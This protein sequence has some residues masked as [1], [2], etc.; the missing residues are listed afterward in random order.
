MKKFAASVLSAVLLLAPLCAYEWGGLFDNT[1]KITFAENS[2]LL[3]QSD[4]LFMWFSASLN[5]EGNIYFKGEGM[6]KFNHLNNLDGWSKNL[7]IIDIDLLKFAG[8]FDTSAGKISASVGRFFVSDFSGA[9]FTQVSDGAY[10]NFTMPKTAISAYAGYTGL[11]NSKTVTILG[12]EYKDGQFYTTATPFVPVTLS[13]SFPSLFMNQTLSVQA[14][15]FFRADG[16]EDNRAYGTLHLSG[17]IASKVF[18]TVLTDFGTKNFNGLMNFSKVSVAYFPKSNIYINGG[19]EY[20]SGE[21]FGLK[22]FNGFSSR[23]AY[24]SL[25]DAQTTGCVVPQVSASISLMENSVVLGANIKS[26]FV[27]PDES[28]EAKGLQFDVNAI[29][30]VFSDLQTAVTL[31]AF[32]GY[33]NSSED[34]L[35]LTLKAAFSF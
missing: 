29:Y 30:N 26:V 20:A 12:G 16:T 9:I 14:S 21:Q 19:I 28:F 7:N 3:D 5:N 34:K 13:A 31:S 2:K 35:S 32:K 8:D 27:C 1:S 22:A 6:F 33:K 24:S 25:V 23:Y 10:V 18:Y 4:S 15:G 17:P 11:L